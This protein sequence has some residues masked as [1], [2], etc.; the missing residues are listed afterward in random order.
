MEGVI[1]SLGHMCLKCPTEAKRRVEGATEFLRAKR[2][3][4][5]RMRSLDRGAEWR[6]LS[7]LYGRMS[8]GEL[9]GLAGR[10]RN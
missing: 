4:I 10:N 7:E 1:K 5:P 3:I 6:R 2:C 8:D 9:V